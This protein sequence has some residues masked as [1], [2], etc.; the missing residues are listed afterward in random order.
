MMA[1]RQLSY[2]N[3]RCMQKAIS[4]LNKAYCDTESSILPFF[5]CVDQNHRQYL[6]EQV[7]VDWINMYTTSEMWPISILITNFFDMRNAATTTLTTM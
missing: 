7:K 5:L 4:P 2:G 6:E 1:T 3:I